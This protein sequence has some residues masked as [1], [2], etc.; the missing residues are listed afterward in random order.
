[1]N[2]FIISYYSIL[3]FSR[4]SEGKDTLLDSRLKGLTQYRVKEC[5]GVLLIEWK[6]I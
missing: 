1:M 6:F 5:R 4:K 2:G 3:F